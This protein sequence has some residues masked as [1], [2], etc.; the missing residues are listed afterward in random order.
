MYDF[1]FK[2]VKCHEFS[3]R[4][5]YTNTSYHNAHYKAGRGKLVI[6]DRTK[7]APIVARGAALCS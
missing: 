3:R 6:A 5:Q 1:A 7:Y 2:I 4:G